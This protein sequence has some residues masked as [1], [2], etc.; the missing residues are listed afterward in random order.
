MGSTKFAR[1]GQ[2]IRFW[3]LVAFPQSEV[4]DLPLFAIICGAAAYPQWLQ[5]V[6]NEKIIDRG[7]WPNKKDG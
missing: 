4:V 2:R 5:I 1:A 6:A 7:D 3:S